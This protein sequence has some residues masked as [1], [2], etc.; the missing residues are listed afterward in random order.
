[1]TCQRLPDLTPAAPEGGEHQACLG[2]KMK[3][4]LEKIVHLTSAISCCLSQDPMYFGIVSLVSVKE[5]PFQSSGLSICFRAI[6]V[7]LAV[8][9]PEYLRL[10]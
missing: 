2:F 3:K 10:Y 8:N 9:I 7:V 5:V 1:M 6:V 4:K